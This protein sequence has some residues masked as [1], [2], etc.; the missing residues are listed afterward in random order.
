MT[1]LPGHIKEQR[2]MFVSGHTGTS[3]FH[4]SALVTIVFMLS[5]QRQLLPFLPPCIRPPELPTPGLQLAASVTADALLVIIP[6]LLTLTVLKDHLTITFILLAAILT[7]TA[8]LAT[9]NTSGP[10]LLNSSS[11]P[12]SPPSVTDSVIT[13]RALLMLLTCTAILAV[14]FDIFPRNYA[15]TERYGTSLMDLGV[16]MFVIANTASQFGSSRIRTAG[17]RKTHVS[18]QRFSRKLLP[19][20]VLAIGRLLLTKVTNY[21][22]HSSE[23]GVHWNFFFTLAAVLSL[24]RLF[25]TPIR[26]HPSQ[27]PPG[28]FRSLTPPVLLLIGYQAWLSC[29][30]GSEWVLS[31]D[32]EA[33]SLISLNKEGICSTVGYLSLYLISLHFGT[34][35]NSSYSA[36]RSAHGPLFAIVNQL[37]PLDLFLWLVTLVAHQYIEQTSRRSCNLAFVCWSLA[38]GVHAILIG[39]LTC[40][41]PSLVFRA[42]ARFMLP[43]FLMANVGTGLVNITMDTLSQPPLTAIAINAT[44]LAANEIESQRPRVAYLCRF[45][46]FEKAHR[47]DPTCKG[48]GVRQF[49]TA[50]LERLERDNPITLEK[51]QRSSDAREI[52]SFYQQYYQNYVKAMDDA[53][54]V[55]RAELARAYQTAGVLFEVLCAINQT[56]KSELAPEVMEAGQRVVERKAEYVAFNILPLDPS[57]AKQPIMQLPEVVAAMGGVTNVSGLPILWEVP[58]GQKLKQFDSLDWLRFVFAFQKDNVRNQR[59]HLVLLL[60]NAH[61]SLKSPRPEPLE[62]LDNRAVEKVLEGLIKNYRSWCRYIKCKSN[63]IMDPGLTPI[64]QQQRKVLFTALFL[65]VWGEAA[66]LRFM[67][68]C[69]CYIYHN[70]AAELLAVLRGKGPEAKQRLPAYG[71]EAEGFLRYVVTPVYDVASKEAQAAVGGAAHSSWRNYDDLNEFFWSKNCFEL[72]WPWNASSPF[73]AGPAPNLHAG[74]FKGAVNC[75]PLPGSERMGKEGFVEHRTCLHLFRD[76]DRMWAFFICCLQA[77]I[78]MAWN[79]PWYSTFTSIDK[80]RKVT[81]IFITLAGIYFLKSLTDV[82][83]SIG[84]YRTQPWTSSLRLLLKAIWFAG[85]FVVLA[86]S[87][88]MAVTDAT[89]IVSTV[90]GWIGVT[91]SPNVYFAVCVLYLVPYVLALG[92][93]IMPCIHRF[94]ENS[95][96]MIFRVIL[97]WSQP[98]EYVGRGMQESQV[99]I[100][101]YTLFW[102]VLIAAKL[103]FSFKFQIEPLVAPTDQIMATTNVVYS[104]H[105]LIPTDLNIFAVITLWAPIILVYFMDTQIWYA[106]M[107]TLLGGITGAFQRL[108]EIRN[109][110]MLRQRFRSLPGAFNANLVPAQR[111]QRSAF[112]LARTYR[113][114]DKNT[115]EAARFAQLWNEVIVSFREE[116]LI[117]NREMDLMM[118]PYSSGDLS[119]VQ[120]PPFLLAS[121]VPRAVEMAVKGAKGRDS[122]VWHRISADSYMRFAVEEAFATLQHILTTLLIGENEKFVVNGLLKEV[123][124]NIDN[125][126]LFTVLRMKALPAFITSVVELVQL[127]A[128]IAEADGVKKTAG[129]PATPGTAGTG[130]TPGG[131]GGG[132]SPDGKGKGKEK[133]E[134]GS[135]KGNGGGK[136]A[137]SQ[138]EKDR[139]SAL[140]R[141]LQDLFEVFTCDLIS[142]TMREAMSAHGG[143]LSEAR[144]VQLFA[145][146]GGA[147]NQGAGRVGV[148]YPPPKT[149]A[150]CEQVKRFLLLL[151]CREA[152]MDVPTNPEARR[153]ICFFTNS[154]F[155]DMPHAPRVRFMPSFS[156]L[157]PYY[158][159]DVMYGARQLNEENEDGVSILFYLQKIYP[160]EWSNF[161]ERMGCESEE[162]LVARENGD[163]ELR[164]WASN[165]GQTLWR[166]VRGMMYYK[167]AME[168]QAFLDISTD[169]E[170]S[171]GYRALKQAARKGD[172]SSRATWKQIEAVTDLKFT[173]VVACQ[174]Y[175]QQKQ[176]GDQRAADIFELMKTHDALR[177]AYIDEVEVEEKGRVCKEYFSVLVKVSR[178][179]EQ[180]IYRVRLP[181]QAK[182]GEG[183]PENQNAAI[184]FTRGEALQAIDMNQDNY[185]EEAFKM[186]NLLQEFGGGEGVLSKCMGSRPPTILGV[187]EH[188]FTGSVSSLGWFMSCQ[189]SSFVTIGQRILAW[190]LK[191]R[192]HYGHPDVFDR[193]FHITRGGVSKASR[194]INLSEDIYA[195]INSTL[196]RGAVTHHEYIQVGKGRDVGLNQISLFEAKVANGNGE[197]ALSRDIY[198]VGSRFDFMRSLSAYFTTVGFY[199][200]SVIVVLTVYAFLYGR[201]YLSLSGVGRSLMNN[202]NISGSDSLQSALSSQALVQLGLLMAL[203]MLMEMGLERGFRT[204]MVDFILMQLQLAS[205][206][207]TFSLGTKAHFFVRTI[208]HGGAKYRPTG[209]GF[210][211]RHE[212]FAENYRLFARSHFTVALEFLL[213][214]IVIAIY[215]ESMSSSN[216]L[217]YFLVTFSMW[218][219]CL[220]WLFAPFVFNPSAFEWQKVVEDWED[221]NRWIGAYGGIGVKG[222]RSWESWWEEEQEHLV[223]TGWVGRLVEV[224]LSLRFL[225]YQYG[226]VYTLDVNNGSTSLLIYGISWLVVLG[227]LIVFKVVSMS[228]R[229]F[230]ADLQLLFRIIKAVTFCCLV[231]A[232]ALII[233][234]T[235][236]TWRDL[237][238]CILAAIPTGWF[239]LQVAQ[240][241]RPIIPSSMWDSVKGLAVLYEYLFGLILFIPI[242]VLAWFPFVSEFQTRLLFNQ[243]F[244]RGLQ[245]SR[246]LA[247]KKKA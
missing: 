158:S 23:Y 219:L 45:S 237:F 187:R 13:F 32:R 2:E 203:P 153:R 167:R 26:H 110:K 184:I 115:K 10:Y 94:L 44:Y 209:R 244:S 214:L 233:G 193:L 221:W 103:V 116:D 33:T 143:P 190:P 232:L 234:L 156:V 140:I 42:I 78:I 142:Q 240:A 11:W 108:G 4:V 7:T 198:R 134:A 168:L 51:R 147:K 217:S 154:L 202:A 56:E 93:W 230:G 223:H 88:S 122:D 216:G 98:A 206:F 138:E 211:V 63:V 91:G 117:S 212:K 178:G 189:E 83:L 215:G 141:G 105:K 16:G 195:G 176:A 86:I 236:F 136:V 226:M 224:V 121:K 231:I 73:F 126:T 46:A 68:E 37:L 123:K 197:Q 114:P 101:N 130:N 152:A 181:G 247:G 28:F 57:S 149:P 69:L 74:S 160:E 166:T 174:L 155:M 128:D 208:M 75:C 24:A 145:A 52:A 89:G 150:W 38:Q 188:I 204:A 48:R 135:S 132:G 62:E 182:L 111:L 161:L 242:A 106:V 9:L 185:L 53:E 246:I 164:A 29:M 25:P 183:K 67:P 58:P 17:A 40:R 192:F 241:I 79:P 49:K 179:V 159:E 199:V 235:S 194:G 133:E 175:G 213:M 99:T 66:N 36:I 95:N 210:V 64:Q 102:V 39:E 41:S 31:D 120:W 8:T 107:S 65:L 18:I 35:L 218:F 186:R 113:E 165:R 20:L 27:L 125:G 97:W 173:Y 87:Y 43:T 12:L 100:L 77:M 144:T 104:W 157:T 81:S 146:A 5:A 61:I 76:F 124:R 15:K 82:F 238:A 196:R 118:V 55:D 84:L 163:R 54:N 201:V 80:F 239:M 60:A 3:M 21:Q 207:F 220:S 72:G 170:F 14:D 151:T 1:F 162:E 171:A 131:G 119:I 59:E 47:L 22:E 225:I 169:Q 129:R 148:L 6:S 180:E 228:S 71:R 191:V 109:L 243:A 70:M 19:L 229:R 245:I 112:S 50:L 92:L 222:D 139:K 227:L 205:V 177:V 90:Q 137:G 30:G 200:S 34:F 85:W 172:V 127:L 96:W